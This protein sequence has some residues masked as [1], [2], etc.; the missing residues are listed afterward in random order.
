MYTYIH[1]YYYRSTIWSRKGNFH[2]K[3]WQKNSNFSE[4]SNAFN[5]LFRYLDGTWWWNG[6]IFFKKLCF[7]RCY[8]S[9][10]SLVISQLFSHVLW[11]F[12]WLFSTFV[13]SLH[14]R[15]REIACFM[16]VGRVLNDFI[17][18]LFFH[19]LTF[20]STLSVFQTLIYILKNNEFVLESKGSFRWSFV[21]M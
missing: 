10:L 15:M 3:T 21:H 20:A 1:L 2:P 8:L 5:F 9:F 12:Q 4:Y 16:S 19:T 14:I 11:H 17:Q 13:I 18:C 6:L 7:Q